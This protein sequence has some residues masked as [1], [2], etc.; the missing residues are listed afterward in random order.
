V[1][2]PTAYNRVILRIEGLSTSL[3][4]HVEENPQFAGIF[5]TDPT[6]PKHPIKKSD[7]PKLIACRILPFIMESFSHYQDDEE[8]VWECGLFDQARIDEGISEVDVRQAKKLL[9]ELLEE[10]G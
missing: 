7:L 1:V 6:T 2:D 3:K 10:L 4:K 5:D 9:N 8:L